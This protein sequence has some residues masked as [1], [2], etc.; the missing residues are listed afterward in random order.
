MPT[1]KYKNGTTWTDL[2]VGQDAGFASPT[3]TINN[4]VGTPG[5]NVTYSGPDSAR[6]YNFAFTNLKGS[7]GAQGGAGATGARGNVLQTVKVYNSGNGTTIPYITYNSSAATMAMTFGSALS[8]TR[9]PT[10]IYQTSSIKGACLRCAQFPNMTMGISANIDINLATRWQSQQLWC[11]IAGYDSTAFPSNFTNIT[12]YMYQ[13]IY[14][15]NDNRFSVSFQEKITPITSTA[16]YHLIGMLCRMSGYNSTAY[17]NGG[18]QGT[19]FTLT[20][21]A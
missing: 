6:Q 14:Y 9:A 13:A 19:T 8:L 16:T 18:L 21:Y 1:L 11:Y 2:T 17:A 12:Y 7:T 5:L 15:I 10:M 3:A 20:R 4:A